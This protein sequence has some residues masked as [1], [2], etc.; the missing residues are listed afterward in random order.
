MTRSGSERK[1]ASPPRTWYPLGD[2]SIR[3]LARAPR[4]YAS[5]RIVNPSEFGGPDL[6]RPL[7]PTSANEN[8]IVSVSTNTASVWDSSREP[9]ERAWLHGEWTLLRARQGMARGEQGV[10][11]AVPDEEFPVSS[12]LLQLGG[13]HLVFTPRRL[14]VVPPR[15]HTLQLRTQLKLK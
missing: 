1:R 9:G 6:G 11:C 8:P 12:A 3:K 5:V 15:H 13:S 7:H 4:S 2:R 14:S 10:R